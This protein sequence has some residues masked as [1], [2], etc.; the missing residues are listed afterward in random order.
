MKG[1]VFTMDRGMLYSALFC[2]IVATASALL[3]LVAIHAEIPVRILCGSR[4]SYYSFFILVP[5]RILIRFL[6]LT[7]LLLL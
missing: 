5:I 6:I 3:T 4:V 2:T 1:T 7:L